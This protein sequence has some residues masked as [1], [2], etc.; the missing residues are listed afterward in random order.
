MSTARTASRGK[1]V[2]QSVADLNGLSLEAEIRSLHALSPETV[3]QLPFIFTQSVIESCSSVVGA[4]AGEALVRRIGDRR[5]G[6]PE[7]AYKRIDAILRSGSSTLKQ[8]IE[9]RFRVRVHRTYRVSMH[10][11]LRRIS[12]S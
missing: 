11:A 2:L 8:A 12:A 7:E 6:N 10:L 9:Q 5:L 1:L 3:S 4:S